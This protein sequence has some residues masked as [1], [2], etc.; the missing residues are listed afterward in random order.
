MRKEEEVVEESQHCLRESWCSFLPAACSVEYRYVENDDDIKVC[1]CVCVCSR[2]RA[3]ARAFVCLSS[4]E[5]IGVRR[6]ELGAWI[7]DFSVDFSLACFPFPAPFPVC[8][9][10]FLSDPAPCLQAQE[11]QRPR[12]FLPQPASEKIQEEN[13]RV[14][15]SHVQRGG[16]GSGGFSHDECD[17]NE[18]RSSAAIM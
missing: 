16:R 3:R 12:R 5:V 14:R 2:A 13:P 4:V 10:S 11:V 8:T 17:D 1:V 18:R 9:R 15:G 6:T 7:C